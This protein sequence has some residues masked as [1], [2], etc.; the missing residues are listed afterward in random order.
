MEHKK[1]HN[2]IAYEYFQYNQTLALLPYI[3]NQSS[4]IATVFKNQA[5]TLLK[6][7]V[8]EFNSQ[9]ENNFNNQFGKMKLIGK[10]YSYPMI[11]VYS[12]KFVANRFALIGDAAVGMHPVTAHG[13]NLG[14][15]GIEI[16]SNEIKLALE[17]KIDIGSSSILRKFQYKLHRIAIPLY[18]STNGIVSLYT[19]VTYPAKLARKYALRI[20]NKIKPVKQVFLGI[21]K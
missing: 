1:P 2:N 11:T 3:N 18:L 16:L 12:K 15:N 6:L 8:N 5:N 7:N 20:V 17:R 14:L 10:R 13:F 9:M 4:I 19:N 21:L